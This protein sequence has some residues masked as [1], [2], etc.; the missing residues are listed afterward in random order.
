MKIKE[1]GIATELF[2]FS[3]GSEHTASPYKK[4]RAADSGACGTLLP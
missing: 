1:F 3:Y 4:A 2:L